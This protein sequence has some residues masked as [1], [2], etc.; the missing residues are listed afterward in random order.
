MFVNKVLTCFYIIIERVFVWFNAFFCEKG[1]IVM[2]HH[3]TN[4]E[5][6]EI[7]ACLCKVERFK[8]IIDELRINYQIVSIDDIY[9]KTEKKKAV[10]TFDDGWMD[11]YMN[12]YPFL[13]RYNIPFTVY[14]TTNFIGKEG[15]IGNSELKVY[16]EDPLVTIGFH[17]Q[18]HSKLR[19]ENNMQKEIFLSRKELEKKVGK[20]ILFLL[21]LMENC[22]PL[23]LEVSFL[24]KKL[25]IRML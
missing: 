5:L 11:A 9:E 2:F 12:A 14:I 10:I 8:E 16:S 7:P 6:D 25:I 22:I 18:S 4:E 24:H 20:A 17:T 21:I 1:V 3:V 23:D 13:K 19:Y 15:Y